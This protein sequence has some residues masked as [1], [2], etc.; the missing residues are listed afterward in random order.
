MQPDHMGDKQVRHFSRGREFRQGDKVNHLREPV[1]DGVV[2]LGG[3]ETGDEVKGN[4]RP[5]STGDGQRVEE[6]GWRTVGGF[7]VRADVA[8]GHK[9]PRV[10][11]KGGPL[12]APADE[13]RRSGGPGVAGQPAGVAPL[14]YLASNRRR[15]EKTVPGAPSRI[16]LGMLGHPHSR[17]D[18]PGN[19]THHPGR[20]EDGIQGR[21]AVWGFGREKSG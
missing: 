19:D 10:H 13:V 9:L 15:D 11:L 1:K 14:Q 2:A 8:G 12:E 7:P 5:W 18:A 21:A 17:F 16:G 3:R 4:V 20:R 6:A